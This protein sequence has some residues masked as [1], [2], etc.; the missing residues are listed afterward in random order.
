MV[1]CAGATRLVKDAEDI[2]ASWWPA[3]TFWPWV[4]FTAVTRP[5]EPKVRFDVV[6]GAIVPDADAA[7]EMVP[8]PTVTSR[9]AATVDTAAEERVLA[10]AVVAPATTS[11]ATTAMNAVPR[12]LSRPPRQRGA[13]DGSFLTRVL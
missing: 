8:V 7:C 6:L 13:K 12:R 10:H 9:V 4:T 11:K 2:V 3:V 5:A 1:A